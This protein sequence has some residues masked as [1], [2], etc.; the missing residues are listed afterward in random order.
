MPAAPDA[1]RAAPNAIEP[2]KFPGSAA[3]NA[4][5]DATKPEKFP[6][7]HVPQVQD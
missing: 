7:T 5:S 4:A 3:G 6:A 1:M 2:R